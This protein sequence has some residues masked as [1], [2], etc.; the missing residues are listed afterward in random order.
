MEVGGLTSSRR[1]A[2]LDRVRP[3]AWIVLFAALHLGL[4]TTFE[5][6][7]DEA[8]YWLFS[9]QLDWGYFDHPPLVALLIRAF[10][11]LGHS[12]VA[13][14]AGFVL[15][16]AG[17]AVLLV[18][19]VA[20]ERRGLALA[21]FFAFPLPSLLGM[22][23]SPDTPLL[24]FSALY[25]LLLRRFLE[26]RDA[27]ATL[28]LALVIPATLYSK[29]H[30]V[31]LILFTVAALPS[32]LK[33]RD[34]YAVAGLSLVLFAPHVAWQAAHDFAS[35]RYHLFE[36]PAGQFSVQKLGEYVGVQAAMAGLLCGPV[37][38]WTVLRGRPA[39]EFHRALKFI[40]LGTFAF[41]LLST[42]SKRF[43]ANWVMFLTVPLIF[44]AVESELWD[45]AWPRRLLVASL[46]LVV[47]ARGL[48]AAQPATRVVRRLKEFHGWRAW[49]GQVRASCDDA[50]LL[51]NGYQVAA[52]LSFYLGEPVHS[53]N[54]DSRKNQFGFWT[55]DARYYA[56]GTACLLTQGE[57]FGGEPLLTPE[58]RKLRRVRHHPVDE[59]RH[60]GL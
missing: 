3:E 41:F 40:C 60:G 44:L 34:F 27:A 37:V 6:G 50:P 42:G 15:L 5:L 38:W 32:L 57:A 18:R 56:S 29:Y 4:A 22:L 21:L 23:A 39:S 59:S 47:P 14:R 20:P 2:W 45:R 11:F 43:E 48:F 17:T 12:E 8:Y 25:F 28:G 53:L 16:Q 55:P 31:L 24:F 35:L 33:R 9:R 46:V 58:G 26:V 13:V 10:S 19:M 51:A 49:A 54:H 1:A 30:G 7:H 52:K 36:R